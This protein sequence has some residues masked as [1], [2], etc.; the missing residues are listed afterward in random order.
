MS[1]VLHAKFALSKMSS[2]KLNDAILQKHIKEMSNCTLNRPAAKDVKV[3]PENIL[4]TPVKGGFQYS[5]EMAVG[6]IVARSENTAQKNMEAAQKLLFK[7]AEM[8][9]W[10]VRNFADVEQAKEVAA[11][12][13]KFSVPPMSEDIMRGYFK[14]I[15]ERESHVRVIHNA[16]ENA[17]LT[18]FKERDNILLF[19]P[20]ATCKTQIVNR[21]KKF[22]ERDSDVERV[23]I[24]NATTTSK[25]GLENWILEKAKDKILPEI[26]FFDEIEKIS[27]ENLFCLLSIM[28]ETAT[29]SRNN[30]KIGRQSAE[31]RCLILASC[32]DEVRLREFASGALWSR[33]SKRLGCGRPKRDVM[34]SILVTSLQD[35]L[36]V[37]E[38]VRL[39]WADAAIN[40]GFDKMKSNDPR[41][42]KSLLSGRDRLLDGSYMRDLE[43]INKSYQESVSV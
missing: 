35:R 7:C 14:G 28:D 36:D 16:V 10:S 8:R 43:A 39:E 23:A 27:P 25:V 6:K 24:I 12:R 40:Y 38:D 42:I 11:D 2:N 41:E 22:Y 26:L 21:F 15:Y 9:G 32:N 5:F 34:R 17:I 13:P 31:A 33:F 19:G 4:C 3:I 20:P 18:E 30:A 37:G 1:N 29:I